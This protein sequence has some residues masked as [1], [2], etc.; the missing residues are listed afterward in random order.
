[1]VIEG[2]GGVSTFALQFAAA[3]GAQVLLT[4]CSDDKLKRAQQIIECESGSGTATR[5]DR[6]HPTVLSGM[7]PPRE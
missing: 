2:T 7:P 1:V 3:A 4:T 6:S 5:L